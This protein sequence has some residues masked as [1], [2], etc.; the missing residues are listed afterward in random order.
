MSEFSVQQGQALDDY[1]NCQLSESLHLVF[2]ACALA[3]A[4]FVGGTVGVV[5]FSR[6][7][8]ELLVVNT[9]LLLFFAASGLLWRFRSPGSRW[10]HPYLAVGAVATLLTAALTTIFGFH[11]TFSD[12]VVIEIA[13]GGVFAL[14]YR[15]LAGMNFSALAC[16]FLIHSFQPEQPNAMEISSIVFA[17]MTSF[18]LCHIRRRTYERE[19]AIGYR[20][21]VMG[22]KLKSLQAESQSYR[23]ELS[24]A[25][26]EL[27]KQ[28]AELERDIEQK[29]DAINRLREHIENS[30]KS[31]SL[32]RMAGGVAHDF[33]NLL[34]VL[35][36]NI[37][38]LKDLCPDD[39]VRNDLQEAR[40]AAKKVT[41]LTSQL[42]A[43]SRRQLLQTKVINPQYHLQRLQPT[44][45]K[46]LG[47]DTRV[48]LTLDLPDEQLELLADPDLLDQAL[49]TLLG[50]SRSGQRRGGLVNIALG[51]DEEWLHYTI[52]HSGW[53]IPQ[54]DS[55]AIA[56]QSD[57]ILAVTGLSLAAVEGVVAQHRGQFEARSEKGYTKYR[58]SLPLGHECPTSEGSFELRPE[59]TSGAI[60]VLEED[61]QVRR[62]L[63]RY[64][65][66]QNFEVHTYS[67][68]EELEYGCGE[69]ERAA[70]LICD[71]LGSKSDSVMLSERLKERWPLLKTVFMSG[72]ES[73]LKR[74]S[75]LD[76]PDYVYLPKP[77]SLE[78]LGESVNALVAV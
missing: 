23:Q 70:V 36:F 37:D 26:K 48:E 76:N 57:D 29:S 22:E 67:S 16:W 15:W 77:F 54:T 38:E 74:S 33:N 41:E 32:G 9:V 53:A 17:V 18:L 24:L 62:L 78:N 64:L 49:L 71:Y 31:E 10:A 46:L 12:I 11:D 75:L 56:F 72:A 19:H 50:L 45:A 69:V 40:S 20:R 8:P 68:N 47:E 1:L 35:F 43:L 2:S 4:I 3:A 7:A 58:V 28:K 63:A 34:T 59:P 39:S 25:I 21:R 14:D 44:I 52:R 13:A 27:A 73:T 51:A 5:G 55:V 66:K 65:R 60:L 6:L 61:D 30:H 42:L